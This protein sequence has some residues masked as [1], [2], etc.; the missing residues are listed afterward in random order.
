MKKKIFTYFSLLRKKRRKG[1]KLNISSGLLLQSSPILYEMKMWV[2][3]IKREWVRERKIIFILW[4]FAHW[5]QY[6]ENFLSFHHSV[7]SLYV[8]RIFNYLYLSHLIHE[9]LWKGKKVK[10][11]KFFCRMPCSVIHHIYIARSWWA[12]YGGICS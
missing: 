4:L 11:G 5:L 1:L 9:R 6:T 10:G 3:W 7:N 8:Q 2:K 12:F